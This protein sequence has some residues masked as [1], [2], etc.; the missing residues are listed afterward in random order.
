MEYPAQSFRL[1][2]CRPDHPGPLAVSSATKFAKSA[3]ELASGVPPNF[4]RRAL[5]IGERRIFSAFTAAIVI[6]ITP[7]A[8]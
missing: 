1:D 7:L 4:T 8:A 2:V 3:G 5:A 6:N